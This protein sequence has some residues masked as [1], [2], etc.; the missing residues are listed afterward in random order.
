[1][2]CLS[3]L[4]FI[5]EMSLQFLIKRGPLSA[6]RLLTIYPLYIELEESLTNIRFTKEDIEGFRYGVRYY[7][8]Y[9]IPISRT[10]NIE[11]RNSQGK[12]MLVRMHTF[13]GINNKKT[14]K[15]FIDIYNKIDEAFFNDMTIHYAQL[16]NGGLNYNLA[17][18]LLTYEGVILKKD[19]A[20]IPWLRIGL[21]SHYR[22]CSIY[23]ISDPQ[24]YRSFDYWQDW[25]ASLLHSVVDCKMKNITYEL[26]K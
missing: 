25:N 9:I 17:G 19:S 11:I 24:H 21:S 4:R 5:T 10:Y 14:E 15:L 7:H 16:L 23:D 12:I 18:A 8:F 3:Y 22:S 1:M 2:F 6:S 26:L 13:F 20:L